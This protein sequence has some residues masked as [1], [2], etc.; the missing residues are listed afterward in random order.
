MFMRFT[1][2]VISCAVLVISGGGV[3][4]MFYLNRAISYCNLLLGT[5]VNTFL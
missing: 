1:H 4:T 5:K 2:R 3:I